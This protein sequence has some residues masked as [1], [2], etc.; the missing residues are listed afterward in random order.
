VHVAGTSNFTD[1]MTATF[2]DSTGNASYNGFLI[3]YNVSG[4]DLLTASRAH[5]GLNIDVDS[6]AT[7]GNTTI[8]HR[9]YGGIIDVNATGDSDL[10]YGL[11]SVAR[12]A[13]TAADT[14]TEVIGVFAYGQGDNTLGTTSTVVGL[15][16]LGYEEGAGTR[17]T[18]YGLQSTVLKQGSATATTTTQYGTYSEIQIDEG[19]GNVTTGYAVRAVV[20]NDRTTTPAA[21]WTTSYLYYGDYQGTIPTTSYGIYIANDVPNFFAGDLN[22]NIA[23]SQ[24]DGFTI[25]CGP[26]T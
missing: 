13:H 8:E 10:I 15:R 9:L 11:Q 3:D 26:Y 5:V 18:T 17:T 4:A 20:N 14:V 22:G 19:A 7:G 16:A 6:T 24:I 1:K 25:D 21:A 23:V 12:S 2:T